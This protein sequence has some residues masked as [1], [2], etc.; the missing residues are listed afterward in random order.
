MLAPLFTAGGH[1]HVLAL[2]RNHVRLFRGT[3]STFDELGT[4]GIPQSVNAALKYDVR[5]SQLQPPWRYSKL[6][7]RSTHGAIILGQ[8][9]DLIHYCSESPHHHNS[10]GVRF[11]PCDGS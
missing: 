9:A 2:G 7:L 1:F 4:S 3:T 6:T 5:E 11:V 8:I 10:V